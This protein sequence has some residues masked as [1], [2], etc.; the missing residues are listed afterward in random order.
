L[1]KIGQDHSINAE[2][3]TNS[4]GVSEFCTLKYMNEVNILR[5]DKNAPYLFSYG[6]MH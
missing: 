6:A 5:K 1:L 2:K 4:K 3:S